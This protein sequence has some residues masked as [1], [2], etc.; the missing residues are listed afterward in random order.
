MDYIKGFINADICEK[1]NITD[2]QIKNSLISVKTTYLKI[3][4]TPYST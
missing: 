2:Y 1:L 4:R 3:N